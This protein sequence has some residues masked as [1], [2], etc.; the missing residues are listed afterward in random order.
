MHNEDVLTAEEHKA[1][2]SALKKLEPGYLPFEI[3]IQ[4]ARLYVTPVIEI[5][6]I[7]MHNDGKLSVVTVPREADDPYWPGALHTPGTVLRVTDEKNDIGSAFNRIIT[8]ELRGVSTNGEPVFV[9]PHFHRNKRGAELAL[10]FWAEVMGEVPGST[11][12]DPNHFPDAVMNFQRGFIRRAVSHFKDMKGMESTHA[13]SEQR[14]INC[15][16]EVLS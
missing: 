15:L 8:D 6:P 2:V 3:F 11:L 1:V 9:Q 4:V 10:I 16:H 7:V 13:Y 5:V 12:V 14:I